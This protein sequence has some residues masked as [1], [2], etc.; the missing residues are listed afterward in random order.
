MRDEAFREYRETGDFN[1]FVKETKHEWVKL[2]ASALNR[3]GA[4]PSIDV[5]DVLQVMLMAC[6][7]FVFE[8]QPNRGP[9]LKTH[10][11]WRSYDKALKFVHKERRSGR[12][13]PLAPRSGQPTYDIAF[14]TLAP[15]ERYEADE[16]VDSYFESLLPATEP[17]QE[18]AVAS[19]SLFKKA[20]RSDMVVS[21]FMRSLDL[22]ETVGVALGDQRTREAF[23]LDSIETAP[24]KVMKAISNVVQAHL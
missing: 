23:A 2:A 18:R 16:F 6:A 15:K 4:P 12:T 7:R 5:D 10:V 19:R 24:A 21:T 13:H 11:I 22:D 8:W 17:N 14:S 3:L 9:S 1:A 20:G